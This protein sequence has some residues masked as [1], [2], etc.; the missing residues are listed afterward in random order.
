M[1]VYKRET[2]YAFQDVEFFDDYTFLTK[3]NFYK[4]DVSTHSHEI[5]L[6]QTGGGGGGGG[7]WRPYQTLKLNNFITVKAITTKFSDFS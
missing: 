3:R 5:N 6:I 4:K 1:Y 7:L 2:N